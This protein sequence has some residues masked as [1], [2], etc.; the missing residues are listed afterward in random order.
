M[1]VRREIVESPSETGVWSQGTDTLPR[2]CAWCLSPSEPGQAG[3]PL[4][5]FVQ[6][7]VSTLRPRGASPPAGMP[8]RRMPAGTHCNPGAM[9]AQ[10]RIPGPIAPGM[11]WVPQQKRA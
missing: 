10:R 3:D 7:V 2:V 9:G 5:G 4:P 8:Q 6:R 1:T 11:Q